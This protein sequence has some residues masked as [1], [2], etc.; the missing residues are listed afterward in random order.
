MPHLACADRRIARF[1]G[2]RPREKQGRSIETR[3]AAAVAS[4]GAYFDAVKIPFDGASVG[5]YSY[6]YSEKIELDQR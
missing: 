6:L 1:A 4:A 5:P 2:A 3:L